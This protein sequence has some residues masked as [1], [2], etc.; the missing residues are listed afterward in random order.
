[1][2]V[3]DIDEAR[4]FADKVIESGLSMS[5]YESEF[6]KSVIKI[7]RS[8]GIITL[9]K[10]QNEL[11]NEIYDKMRMSFLDNMIGEESDG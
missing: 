3:F 4:D 2:K 10:K 7:T 11:Y 5:R 9:T 6:I 8:K 1:M